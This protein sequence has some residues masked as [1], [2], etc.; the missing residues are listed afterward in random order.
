VPLFKSLSSKSIQD[1]K[2]AVW[3]VS[4]SE[5][6]LHQNLNLSE[7][8][9]KRLSS[10][11]SETHRKCFL[12]VRQLL[13]TYQIEDAEVQYMQSGRPFLKNG[14]SISISHTGS[15]VAIALGFNVQVGVDIEQHREKILKI[16]SRFTGE[17]AVATLENTADRIEKLTAIWGAKESIYKI[18]DRV[19]L[20]FKESIKIDDFTLE[21]HHSSA[22]VDND[23]FHFT[24]ETFDNH[25]LVYTYQTKALS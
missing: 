3:R 18:L 21:S 10:M 22:W 6:D 7:S 9:K 19:G 12:A 2:V 17:G 1:Y 14:T 25:T 13:K 11:K 8:S 16:A 24:F 15:Y 5:E 20:S 4:E 23:R